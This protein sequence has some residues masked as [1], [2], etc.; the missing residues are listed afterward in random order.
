V[1]NVAGGIMIPSQK[2]P[3]SPERVAGIPSCQTGYDS[4]TATDVANDTARHPH[5][6]PTNG[7][8]NGRPYP[9]NKEPFL[10]LS[11]QAPFR[12]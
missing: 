10:S 3:F 9:K 12:Q 11:K 7:R 8:K 6:H 5:L 1:K 2:S 4:G